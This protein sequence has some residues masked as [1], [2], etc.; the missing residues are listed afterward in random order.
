MSR[1][2]RRN[3][4]GRRYRPRAWLHFEA[5]GE[6]RASNVGLVEELRKAHEPDSWLEV[7]ADFHEENG[8]FA[9]A[10][11]LRRGRDSSV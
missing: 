6:R 7:L 1:S 3:R 5:K 4:F 10:E 8:R 9:L 11:A 2:F